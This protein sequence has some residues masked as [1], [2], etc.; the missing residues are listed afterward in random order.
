MG[1]SP[2]TLKGTANAPIKVRQYPF[3]RAIIDGGNSHFVNILEISGSYTWYWGFEIMS[4]DP[5]RVSAQTSSA[6]SDIGRGG[7]VATVQTSDTGSGLKFINLVIH[8][9]AGAFGL[10]QQA[11][12]A[13]VYGCLIYNNGW[14]A[15]DRGH[16][17]GIYVQNQTS[18]KQITDNIIFNQFSHGIHAYSTAPNLDGLD[19]EGNVSFDN[20]ILSRVSGPARNLLIGEAT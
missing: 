5:N 18:T 13:E 20:G 10:W 16:G 1:P 3:E 19:I 12:D 7:G 4:S 8:D 9:T 6:P 2:P 17:H 15:P 14:D 11:I